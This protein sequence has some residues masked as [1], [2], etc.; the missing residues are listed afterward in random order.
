MIDR[1]KT[2]EEKLNLNKSL[3]KHKLVTNSKG[4]VLKKLL[5]VLNSNL[6]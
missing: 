1:S 5:P 3:D 2:P 6:D 4:K